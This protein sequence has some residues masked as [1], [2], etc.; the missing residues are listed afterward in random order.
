MCWTC[1]SPARRFPR[2]RTRAVPV[3]EPLP[4]RRPP[5][6]LPAPPSSLSPHSGRLRPPQ[7][8]ALP[9]PL[10]GPE[11]PGVIVLGEGGDGSCQGAPRPAAGAEAAAA[12][13]RERAGGLRSGAASGAGSP[14]GRHATNQNGCPGE[15][16]PA[17]A[18]RGCA[19]AEPRR[20]PTPLPPPAPPQVPSPS[21]GLGEPRGPAPRGAAAPAARW[22]PAA[23]SP[24]GRS[25]PG[26]RPRAEPGRTC[27]SARSTSQC[28]LSIS[29]RA[30]SCWM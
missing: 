5:P 7:A 2:G 11:S 10:P 6:C 20:P 24:P 19:S 8:L 3:S 4:L 12:L 23:R 1:L 9:N 17:R 21:R 15:G 13:R 30:H 18:V 26:A 25:R 22:R 27:S 28:A 16:S 29:K 14:G